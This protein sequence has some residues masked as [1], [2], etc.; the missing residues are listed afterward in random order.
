MDSS[1][2][3]DVKSNLRVKENNLEYSDDYTNGLDD[4]NYYE[5]GHHFEDD[6]DFSRVGRS[7]E[8]NNSNNETDDEEDGNICSLTISAN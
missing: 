1:T 5:N 4:M 6:Y 7:H 2:K 8:F 3:E